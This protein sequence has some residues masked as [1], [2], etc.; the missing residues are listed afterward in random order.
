MWKDTLLLKNSHHFDKAWY[1]AQNFDV[2]KSRIDPARHYLLHGYKEGREPSPFFS[3]REY[4]LNNSDVA[5][6][7]VNPLVHYLRYGEK[8]GRRFYAVQQPAKRKGS[9]AVRSLGGAIEIASGMSLLYVSGEPDIPGNRYRVTRYIEAAAANQV[10]A[11]WIRAD[12]LSARMHQVDKCQV[13]VIWRAPWDGTIAEAVARVRAHGCKVVF[14]VDDLMT[15]PQFAQVKI[16]DGI[17]SQFL[18]EDDVRRHYERIRQTMLA[19]DICFTTTEELAFHMRCA[20]K[21]THVLPNGFDD[22]AHAL[23]RRSMVEWRKNRD[24]LIRIGYAGGTHTHQRDFGL[25]VGAVTRLLR[26]DERCRLVLFR[27]PDGA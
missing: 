22:A 12:E 5:A 19:A 27:T 26:E 14:D 11:N 6:A 13:L 10:V 9:L 25:A 24:S 16:I 1:V 18:M 23:S 8:E 4:L 2:A 17:R 20:G 7:G 3:G 15:E 21:T